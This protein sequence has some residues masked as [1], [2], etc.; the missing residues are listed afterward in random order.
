MLLTA[1]RAL[2]VGDGWVHEAKLDGWRCLVEVSGSRVQ[3]WSRRG[4]DYTASLPELQS[5][6][7]VGDVVM[8]GELVVIT[9]DGRAD[10][11]LLSTRVNGKNRASTTDPPVTLYAFDIL[12][13]VGRDLCGE[14]WT[15]R[16][17][18]V[19]QLDL[20]TVTSGA[21]G[22]CRT[23]A[24]ARRCIRPPSPLGPRGRSARRRP[25]STCRANE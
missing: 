1:A 18:I 7:S 3:V 12:R 23:P 2:P 25:A 19:E 9:D 22:R 5:L 11:E 14:P 21:F 13:H 4:G 20:A 15:A 24:T 6:S 10:F 17:A 16:R 8:D